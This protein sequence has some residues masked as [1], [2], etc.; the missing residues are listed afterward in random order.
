VRFVKEYERRRLPMVDLCSQFGISRITGYKWVRRYEEGGAEALADRSH[1][2]YQH[3]S[4]VPEEVEEAVLAAR[5][6]HPRWGPVKLRIWLERTEPRVSWPA[7][8]TIGELLRRNGLTV[9]RKGRRNGAVDASGPEWDVDIAGPIP[10]LDGQDC[11]PVMIAD[12]RTGSVIRCQALRRPDTTSLRRLFDAAFREYGL[13]SRIRAPGAPPFLY[14]CGLS[15]L[16]V[17]WIR[18]GIRTIVHEPNTLP[19]RRSHNPVL[20][21][22]GREAAR[23]QRTN[24]RQ[25]QRAL[26]SFRDCYN[27]ERPAPRH[28]RPYTSRVEP[29]KYPPHFVVRRVQAR[30]RV[31]WHNAWICVSRASA[32]EVLGF[33][34]LSHGAWRVWFSFHEL[35]QLDEADRAIRPRAR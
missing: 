18:L 7:P 35:G 31:R 2:P 14:A 3:P 26:T 21:A 27:R 13:P 29:V 28:G 12:S 24:L 33:E 17:W 25:Q 15:E 1:A 11:F 16:T 23:L 6:E 32:G 30:G 22:L 4:Q 34:P 9:A 20:R 8:S 5:S 19:G 10:S